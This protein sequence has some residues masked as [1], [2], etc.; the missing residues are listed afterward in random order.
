MV[1]GPLLVVGATGVVGGGIVAA[2]LASGRK[3]IAAGR[4]EARLAALAA[5]HGGAALQCVTGNLSSKV[6]AGALLDRATDC[7]GPVG[8][9]V[10]SVSAAKRNAPL[11]DWSADELMEA[12]AG[13]VISHFNAAQTFLP[14]L[15]D[16]GMYIAI[17]GGTADFLFPALVPVSMAQAA[18]RMMYR[19]FT[20]ERKSGAQLHELMIVSMVAGESNR[21]VAPAD[22]I[23]DIEVGRHVCAILDDP[24]RFP[25]PILQLRSRQQVGLPEDD[26]VK[27]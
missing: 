10:V 25:K 22:W 27:A 8:A 9:V 24:D 11:D 16:A 23:T 13:D 20:K 12:Y 7:F 19:G 14:R 5:R 26:A 21:Q 4:N 2:G 18:L 17:G 1:S 3:V 15:G 6:N